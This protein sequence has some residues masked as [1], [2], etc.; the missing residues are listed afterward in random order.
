MQTVFKG[1]A[2]FV[3]LER[4]NLQI[5]RFE[6]KYLD[7]KSTKNPFPSTKPAKNKIQPQG[8]RPVIHKE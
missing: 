6:T 8:N 5:Y 4:S 1:L 3:I 2:N 7:Q